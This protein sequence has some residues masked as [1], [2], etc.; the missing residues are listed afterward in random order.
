M[1]SY[2]PEQSRISIDSLADFLRLPITGDLTEVPGISPAQAKLLSRGGDATDRIT[3]THQ[4]I[5][6][7]LSFYGY[8]DQTGKM[9]TTK[10]HCDLFLRYLKNKGLTSHRAAIVQA[11]AEKANATFPGIYDYNAFDN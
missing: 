8:N 6:K 5:G 11:I 3:T 4:L 10:E 2:N 9:V 7:F 1:D